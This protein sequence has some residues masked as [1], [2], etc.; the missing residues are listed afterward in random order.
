VTWIDAITEQP[1][2]HPGWRSERERVLAQFA[3]A[4]KIYVERAGGAQ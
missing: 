3:E 2:E 1:K 4:R